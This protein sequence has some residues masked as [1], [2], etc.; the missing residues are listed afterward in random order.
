MWGKGG[1]CLEKRGRMEWIVRCVEG[2]GVRGFNR[3]GWMGWWR[4]GLRRGF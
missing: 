2:M 4:E 3:R 1:I